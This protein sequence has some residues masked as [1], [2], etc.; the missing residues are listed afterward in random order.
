[1]FNFP[2]SCKEIYRTETVSEN[3]KTESLSGQSVNAFCEFTEKRGYTFI[4]RDDLD[5]LT[6]AD[7]AGLH[8]INDHIVARFLFSVR[9]S[10]IQMVLESLVVIWP[11]FKIQLDCQKIRFTKVAVN[12]T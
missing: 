12:R 5:L 6:D 10:S 3:Y 4:H 7:L 9:T 11:Y 2:A 1:M 8:T